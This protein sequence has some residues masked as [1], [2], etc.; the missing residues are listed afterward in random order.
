M[1]EIEHDLFEFPLGHLPVADPDAGLGNQ[2]C[3]FFLDRCDVLDAIV[4]EINLAAAFDLAQER[5]ANDDVVPFAD[6]CLDS[7]PVGRRRCNQ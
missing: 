5:F 6:E 2:S 3:N 1:I 7:E 4:Y